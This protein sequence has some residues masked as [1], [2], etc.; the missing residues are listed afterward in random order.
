MYADHCLYD[1][2]YSGIL[3]YVHK[4]KAKDISVKYGVSLDGD[5]TC[6]DCSGEKS[7]NFF[8]VFGTPWRYD[9]NL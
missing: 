1:F 2:V 6:A 9:Y 3:A 5:A 8:F 7:K 4:H